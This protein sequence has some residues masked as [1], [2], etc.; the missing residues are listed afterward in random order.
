MIILPEMLPFSVASLTFKVANVSVIEMGEVN[1]L[2]GVL[3]VKTG[4][5]IF[6]SGFVV[7]PVG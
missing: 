5:C 6:S 7:V 1:S 3:K 4:D 2:A